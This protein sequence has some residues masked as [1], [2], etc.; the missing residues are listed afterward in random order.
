MTQRDDPTEL[1]HRILDA[2]ERNPD[3]G[4]AE[5]ASICDCSESYVRQTLDSYGDP[6]D[7]NLFGL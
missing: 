1:Q 5:L 3:A 7:R 4:V 2:A 6:A